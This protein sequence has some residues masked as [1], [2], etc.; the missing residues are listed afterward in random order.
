MTLSHD[1]TTARLLELVYG[2][3]APPERA[4]L[5]AHVATGA[6][7]QAELATLGD[8]R[9]RLRTALDDARVPARAHAR[10]LQAAAE[11]QAAAPTLRPVASV[12]PVVSAAQAAATRAAAPAPGPSF[13]ERLRGRWT[14]PTLAT[15]GAIAIVLFASKIFL[16][17]QLTV[18]RGR[19][20]LAPAA[21]ASTFAAPP[22]DDLRAKGGEARGVAADEPAT[23]PA[24]Q[25]PSEAA[26]AAA[27]RARS[28]GPGR[29]A[30]PFGGLGGKR[31]A[32]AVNRSHGHFDNLVGGGQGVAPANGLV[33]A[34]P[35]ASS[36]GGFATP[37][38]PVAA[39]PAPRRMHKQV[40]DNPFDDFAA[41]SAPRGAA[42]REEDSADK[43][44]EK[45]A[46]RVFV[47]KKKSELGLDEE[48]SPSQPQSQAPSKDAKADAA[49]TQETLAHRAEQLFAARRWSEAIA[50][51]R[52]LLRRF[53]DAELKTRW[54]AR[55]TQAEAQSDGASGAAAATAA[56]S[57]PAAKPAAKASK[58]V[59][60]DAVPAEAE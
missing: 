21:P 38:P 54:R 19:E 32:Q 22:A 6:Q 25:P 2:E 5:E 8:T 55:L 39:A 42:V 23:R 3:A 58:K 33:G 11:A 20:A 46:P 36:G 40:S 26:Q 24:A 28:F 49:P 31:I 18:E 15:V 59:P 10:I 53:P 52:E 43:L 16:D 34:A 35:P 45:P 41:S 56:R 51:Y 13:W 30:T 12:A 1:E 60:V 37:P 27:E 48:S 57:A 14:F 9:A 44:A 47:A 50:A 7:C 4:A 17:P 29:V